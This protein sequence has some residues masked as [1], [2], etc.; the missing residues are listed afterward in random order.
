MR[1][2]QEHDCTRNFFRTTVRA[3]TR[4]PDAPEYGPYPRAAPA[5]IALSLRPLSD[6]CASNR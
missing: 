1:R 2:A 3:V 5:R 6:Q 4:P